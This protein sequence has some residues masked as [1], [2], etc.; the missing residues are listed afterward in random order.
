MSRYFKE[1]GRPLHHDSLATGWGE[2][3]R[4]VE[5]ADDHYAARQV[6][7]YT[8]GRVLRYD[9]THWCDQFGQLF[10]CLFSNKQKAINNRPTAVVIEQTEFEQAWISALASPLWTQQIEHSLLDD[11]GTVPFW[12]QEGSS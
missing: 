12:L 5:I 2:C 10:G 7:D 4:Y 3:V 6:E 8:H 11:R 1:H 9:R